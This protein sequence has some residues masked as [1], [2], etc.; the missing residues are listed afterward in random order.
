MF[1]HIAPTLALLGS[2]LCSPAGVAA[3]TRTTT[4]RQLQVMS[5]SIRIHALPDA[6]SA[7]LARADRGTLLAVMEQR[8]PWFRVR[9]DDG[10]SGWALQAQAEY[11][12]QS[13]EWIAVRVE[14]RLARAES[15]TTPEPLLRRP[16]EAAPALVTLPGEDPAQLAPPDPSL[17][18]ESLPVPDR[19]RLMQALGFNFPWYDPYNQNPLKGDLPLP[20]LG[21]QVFLNLGAVLDTVAEFRR[22][23]TP[24]SPTTAR[25][26]GVTDIF[27]DPDQ[28][29]LAGTLITSLSLVKGNTTFRPP[30]WEFRVTPVFNLN[31]VAVREAGALRADPNDCDTVALVTDEGPGGVDPGAGDGLDGGADSGGAGGAAGTDPGQFRVFRAGKYCRRDDNFVGIQE[32][33][34][35]RHLRNVSDR[36]DFDSLR[37]GIQPFTSDFRGFLFQDL[38]FGVRLFGNRDNNRWQYNLAWFRRLEKDTN[39]GLND[40]LAAWR[41]DDIFV[42]NVYRQDFPLTGFTSQLTLLH[43][44]NTETR[45]YA[46][47]NGFVVRPGDVGSVAPGPEPYTVN[48]LGYSGDGHLSFL[49][50]SLRLNLSTSTYFAVGEQDFAPI[51]G[52]KQEIR[53]FFHASELSR[54][55]SWIRLRGS[56]LYASG[57]NDPLDGSARGFDAILENP[58]FAGADT[59]YW[60][61][62]N[63]PL[64]GGGSVALSGRNGVLP[65]LRTSKDQ[66]QANFVNPGLVLFGVGADFDITPELRLIANLNHLRFAQAGTLEFL[67]V[68]PLGSREIGWDLSVG[69]Q[70]RPFYNQNVVVNASAAMLEPSGALEDLFGQGRHGRPVTA[71]LSAVASF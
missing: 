31:R 11:G 37:V 41:D 42:A 6:T 68:Q 23:P 22:I 18:R 27:G 7:V 45:R 59:S 52:R 70:W 3:D 4:Q 21:E 9:L 5:T 61:R 54:D 1:R 65:S 58:Q 12:Q 66:G 39:S 40:T 2:L 69:I 38:P 33:F 13:V 16:G 53:A 24:V 57:D 51:A 43:E 25:E 35:D 19:W 56:F 28:R 50:P 46:D 26:G 60:I 20:Q 64:V 15:G 55:F 10:A 62:Q 63:I 34:Y 8:G 49:W 71:L 17:P 47:K 36:Y 14:P 30:D 67:R 48:Y 44:R 32:L 29:I